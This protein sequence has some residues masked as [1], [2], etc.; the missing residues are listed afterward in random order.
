MKVERDTDSYRGNICL[1]GASSTEYH[2][3]PGRLNHAL[4][5]AGARG[6][7]KWERIPW[8]QAMDE[9]ASR[10]AVIR[11]RYGPEAVG[12]LGGFTHDPADAA[13]WKWCNRWGTPNFFH[14]GKNC[15]E[16]EYPVECAMY[17]YDTMNSWA[18]RIDPKK[19]GVLIIWGTNP[20]VSSSALWR[21]YKRAQG[22][23]LKIVVVDPKPTECA[24]AADLWLRL[25]PGTDG[26]L[27]LGMLQVI[28]SEG[29]YDHEFVEK[30]C[31][32]FDQVRALAERWPPEHAAEVTG[33][34][35]DKIVAAARMYAGASAAILT[36]GVA[37]SGLG[38]G[39][40]LSS[41]LAKCWLRAIT[42][43]LDRDGGQFFSQPPYY[44]NF[45]EEMDW[46]HLIN[47][48]QRT[49]DNVSADIRGIGSVKALALFKEGMK[50][51]YPKG[52][53]ASQYFVYPMPYAVWEA[54]LTGKPY[55][56]KALL[57]VATN[58]LCSMGGAR[59]VY[60]AFKS[61]R[62]ELHVVMEHFLT[63]TAAMA[64]YVLPATD[65]L[66]RPGFSNNWG[67][68]GEEY[69]RMAAVE[70]EGERRDVYQL[71]CDLGR[72]LGQAEYWPDSLE[73]WLD[74]ILAPLNMSLRQLAD[75]K[76]HH[77]RRE[78][79]RYRE[80]GFGTFSGKVELI[81]SLLERL[82]CDGLRDGY[83]ESPWNPAG[84]PRMARD[85]PLCLISG[86]RVPEFHISSHRQIEHLRKL[87]PDPLVE[88]NPE[89]A[90]KLGILEGD[91]VWVETPLGRVRQRAR[92]LE[93]LAPDVVHS[94]CGWWFPERGE[95]DPTFFGTWESNINAIIP[96]APELCD[97]AGNNYFRGLC[98]RVSRM[99]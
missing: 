71:W 55:P 99:T 47:H 42:G 68:V 73:K 12:A 29:S 75:S 64:D 98:C 1:R 36:W 84:N 9:I 19:T 50:R 88:I 46:D 57:T 21:G 6:E 90:G 80:T 65:G 18:G 87:H 14:L 3:H 23:G 16:A 52:W 15:G 69:G 30:W 34:P 10:L 58:T 44:T 49:R 95:S 89:T 67:M 59:H 97:F 43:N 94:E 60:E 17:G 28:I 8:D 13:M 33:V 25:R 11:D 27:A 22:A 56:I 26:A 4:K 61:D 76:G 96:D 92:I 31:L 2:Y 74:R 91:W 38:P 41:A 20:S 5:R 51:V 62:L 45:M 82:G 83:R 39:A 7:G 85:Y 40:G 77:P 24:R 70:P 93:G 72:R 32:G 53:G 48:P 35:A 78:Y 66:E 86:A 54:I 63:P 79:Q 37:S 81:P